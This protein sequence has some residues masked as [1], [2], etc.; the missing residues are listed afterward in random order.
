M[1]DGYNS[2]H[3]YYLN[4]FRDTYRQVLIGESTFKL[5]HTLVHVCMQCVRVYMYMYVHDIV[6]V[7]ESTIIVH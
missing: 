7:A 5:G 4:V 2:A 1:K 3:R 6:H